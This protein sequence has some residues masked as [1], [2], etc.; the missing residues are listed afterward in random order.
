MLP[1]LEMFKEII[2]TPRIVAYNESFVPIGKRYKNVHACAIIW[3][4]GIAGRSKED[5]IST[6]Y[7]FFLANRDMNKITIWLD[8]CSSQNK[9]WTLISFFIYAVNS[10]EIALEDLVIKYFEP[11]HTF[12]A[13]DSF[14]H[15]VELSLKRKNKVYDF[16]DF[17]SV[18]KEA[19]SSKVTV[20][21]MQIG[22]FFKWMDHTSKYKLQ[23]LATRVYLKD[24]VALSFKRG[25]KI[26]SFKTEFKNE[27]EEVK[28][29][30]SQKF[31]KGSLKRGEQ[32]TICRGVNQERKT[33]LISKL[34]SHIPA[35]RLKF[36]MDLPVSS[37]TNEADDDDD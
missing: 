24:I 1:R 30:F 12:M 23:R 34:T 21:E 7:A 3:H 9:N 26:F 14:H 2:F 25:K 28:D 5:L 6:F 18:V 33:T 4:E 27:F 19:N 36:W 29:I 13:A 17:A 10:S 15:Q 35:N 20:I 32:R 8:N 16:D 22:Q 31:L 37:N 11:G